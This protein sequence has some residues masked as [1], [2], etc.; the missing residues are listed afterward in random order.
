MLATESRSLLGG[1]ALGG[2]SG[3]A[4]LGATD[5]LLGAAREFASGAGSGSTALSAEGLAGLGSADAFLGAAREGALVAGSGSTALGAEGLAG[6]GSADALLGA[7]GELALVAR[8]GS[9]ALSA[10]GLAGL[11]AAVALLGAARELALVARSL[12]G[13][14]GNLD[15]S[16]F[17]SDSS[18]HV[19]MRSY[20]FNNIIE[21]IFRSQVIAHRGY[22]SGSIRV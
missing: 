14:L 21:Y 17:L 16:S 15:G 22:I 12:G 5:A 10:E 11:G 19:E 2:G 1:A 18:C 6:L 7:A 4:G 8:S 13:D 3:F 9:T 20:L